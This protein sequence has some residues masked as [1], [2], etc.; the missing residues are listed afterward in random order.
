MAKAKKIDPPW[1]AETVKATEDTKSTRKS[2]AKLFRMKVF[3]AGQEATVEF[4]SKRQLAMAKNAISVRCSR[5]N[6]ADFSTM[7]K[8]YTFVP[9]LGY[10]V[11]D[12]VD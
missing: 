7:G 1:A 10:I 5:G 11:T 9:N 3:C 6:S 8:E 4:E 12:A 2:K